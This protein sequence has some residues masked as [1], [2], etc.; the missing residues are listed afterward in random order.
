ML[1]ARK[2]TVHAPC[3]VTS[4]QGV[5]NDHIFGIP[6]A[7]LPIHCTTFMGLWW[8]LRGVYRWKFYTGAFLLKIFQVQFWAQI[9]TLGAFFRGQILISNFLTPKRHTLAWDRVVC[10]VARGNPPRGLTCR[11]VSE[12]R[13]VSIY[14]GRSINKLQNGAI[15]LILKIWK[16]RN[17]RFVGNLILNIQRKFLDDD[18]IIVTSSVH[19]TQSIGVLFSPPVFCH[20]S[21]FITLYTAEEWKKRI[22][23]TS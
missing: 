16:I 18:V 5:K 1:K 11:W 13:Y 4:R 21:Q 20:N 10:A 15:P 7:I 9:S 23:L 17:I 22:S 8:R 12:K 3:H 19:R 6:M 14:E 2:F